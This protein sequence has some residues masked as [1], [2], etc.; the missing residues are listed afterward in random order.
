MSACGA[1]SMLL[2]AF[3]QGISSLIGAVVLLLVGTIL[4]VA[5]SYQI[6]LKDQK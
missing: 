3:L 1:A 6:F 4:A 2:G 5:V